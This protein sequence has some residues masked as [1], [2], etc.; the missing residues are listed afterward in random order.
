MATRPRK[1]TKTTSAPPLGAAP[2]WSMPENA[3]A[4]IA[5][6]PGLYLILQPDAPRFTIV[7]VSDAY[8]HATMTRREEII[9]KGLFEV[10]PDNPADPRA[11][12]VSNLTASLITVIKTGQPHRMANQKYDI[13][14]PSGGF[15]ER[16]WSPHNVPVLNANQKIDYIIHSVVDIT[17][18]INLEKKDRSSQQKISQ[19]ANIINARQEL[20]AERLRM[21]NILMQAPA[22]IAIT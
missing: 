5:A 14:L 9:G 18:T 3:D 19:Q 10:F 6:I 7:A 17:Q 22:M 13:P 16:W 4:I 8:A 21:K 20:E 2:E 12:G 1:K 11:T 15:E